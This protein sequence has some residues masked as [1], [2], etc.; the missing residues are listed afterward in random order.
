MCVEGEGG[1]VALGGVVMVTVSD[2]WPG[3]GVVFFSLL[4][5]RASEKVPVLI[6]LTN[7]GTASGLCGR[8]RRGEQR[9]KHM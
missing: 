9:E 3:G 2:A 6:V 8:G 5:V 1:R 4:R 7:H